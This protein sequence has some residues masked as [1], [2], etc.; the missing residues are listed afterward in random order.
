MVTETTAP[1]PVSANR[2]RNR[3]RRLTI[4]GGDRSHMMLAAQR[5]GIPEDFLEEAA[6][7]LRN[8][9]VDHMTAHPPK[10]DP[11]QDG[12]YPGQSARLWSAGMLLAALGYQPEGLS[13]EESM[14][15]MTDVTGYDADR[16]KLAA[17]YS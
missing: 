6:K 2:I 10:P 12:R 5:L 7:F 4:K 9:M 1:Q 11:Q 13:A 16:A 8:A 3:A 14:H 15:G 17:S